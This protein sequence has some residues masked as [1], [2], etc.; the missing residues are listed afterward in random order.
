MLKFV[1]ISKP[2]SQKKAILQKYF[3]C[4]EGAYYSFLMKAFNCGTKI[5]DFEQVNVSWDNY[6][7]VKFSEQSC[8]NV[9]TNSFSNWFHKKTPGKHLWWCKWL[10]Y[11]SFGC[12]PW[13]LSKSFRQ[14]FC[15]IL[16]NCC[17]WNLVLIKKVYLGCSQ[18]F[19][20]EIFA[21]A[22]IT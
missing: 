18:I 3:V 13:N 11:S 17:F 10:I 14:S 9:L 4:K 20:M 6:S 21:K 8:S 2:V 22:V 19:M 15:K 7:V 12:I 1:K 5:V 16:A